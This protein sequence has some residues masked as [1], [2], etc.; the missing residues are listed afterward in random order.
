MADQDSEMEKIGSRLHSIELRL[1]KLEATLSI[2][3]NTALY[4][5]EPGVQQV[6]ILQNTDVQD[7][8]EKG[9]ESKIGRFGLAW[10]GNIVLL[11][12]I[13]FL[14]QYM[15]NIGYH[16]V[17][18][19]I[20]YIAAASIFFL[21]EYLK[22]TNLHLAFM[23]KMNAQILLFFITLRLHFFSSTPIIPN[24][25]ISLVL[26]LLIIVFQAYLAISNKSQ[27]FAALAVIF[28]LTTAIISDSTHFML[29]L[30]IL[31]AAGATWAFQ[32]YKWEALL[33]VTII[34]TY[35]IYFLWLF[36]NPFMG[37][38]MEMITE[39]HFGI[40]YLFG[41]GA[42]FCIIPFFRK[43]DSS[44]DDF[45]IGVTVINGILFTLLLALVTLRFFSTNY[46]TLFA[47]ITISCLIYSTILKST[48]DWNF[49]SAFFALYGFM[50]MSISL[51]GLFGLPRVYLLLSLQS[52]VVVSMALW[53][54]N[55]LIIIMNSLLF[56]SILLIYLF[57][58][59]PIDG[60]NF[61]FA[62]VPLISARIINWKKSR[63]KIET[64]LMRNL[65]L[66]EGFFMVLYA[67]YHAV[68]GQFVTLSWTMA[69]LL[70]FV[71]S[72]V[73]KNVKYRYMA[74]GTMI[75]AAFYLFIV[76]LARIE[77][78]YRVLALLFLAA[79]S[80]GIS[81]YYTNRVKK[82]DN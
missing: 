77:I 24:K 72:F 81:M 38:T 75:C 9:L 68:P 76:D 64:D 36:G 79:I 66:I 80:I 28:A 16:F 8:E 29:P 6:D 45:L 52:L 69:A 49:A 63:L 47:V 70:H 58:A 62:L 56:L 33:I 10:L 54:R 73:L 60:V 3:D 65:Y 26:L 43:S 11:F 44:Y 25:T 34:L 59:K 48:S 4:Q 22:K 74:L 78:I 23:F 30:V 7:E 12:G 51:Y 32:K 57:S 31:T 42:C 19:L 50:A 71:L 1:S 53:F 35:I 61:S 27:A 20:G 21:E 13:G 17:S 2:E 46:V 5:I 82:S 14:T 18:I 37:H 39:H 67:L 41:L 40:A 15:M 55:R